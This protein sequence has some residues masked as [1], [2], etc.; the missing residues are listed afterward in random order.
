[1]SGKVAGLAL[2]AASIL[3]AGLAPA[4]AA[5]T[6][7]QLLSTIAL[8]A[9][10]ANNQGGAFTAFDISYVDPITGDYYVA[11]RSNASVDIIS[12]SSL[13][14]INQ[15]GGF[16]GQQATTSVSGPDGVL[17]AN[18]GTNATLFA[19][20]G[21]STLLS[22][23]VTNPTPHPPTCCWSPTMPRPRRSAR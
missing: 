1:M 2:A 6:D 21:N 10:A 18:N 19:G 11:D 9:T 15:V 5:N 3:A 22:F 8:P 7:Y 14:V 16:T 13:Q 23:N 4:R 17:V 20:N 12:G